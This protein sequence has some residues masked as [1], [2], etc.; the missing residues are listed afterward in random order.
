VPLI[1]EQNDAARVVRLQG[2][3]DIGCAAELKELLVELLKTGPALR[4]SLEEATGLDVTAVQLLWAA[5]REAKQAGVEFAYEGQA[6]ETVQFAL[7]QAGLGKFP[8]QA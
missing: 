4:V 7:A 2:A 6:P 1:L 3:I 8:A 5:A